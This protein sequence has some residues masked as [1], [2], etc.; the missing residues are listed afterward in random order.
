MRT[1]VATIT[2]VVLFSAATAHAVTLRQWIDKSLVEKQLKPGGEQAAALATYEVVEWLHAGNSSDR[3]GAEALAAA[4]ALD[5]RRIDASHVAIR[6]GPARAAHALPPAW[7]HTLAGSDWLAVAISPTASSP[8]DT[9]ALPSQGWSS[10]PRVIGDASKYVIDDSSALRITE[11]ALHRLQHDLHAYTATLR[12]NARVSFQNAQRNDRIATPRQVPLPSARNDVEAVSSK[13]PCIFNPDAVREAVDLSLDSGSPAAVL[14]PI[15]IYTDSPPN[16]AATMT[17]LLRRAGVDACLRRYGSV[18]FIE[19]RLSDQAAAQ[20]AAT[21]PLWVQT[22][23]GAKKV[24]VKWPAVFSSLSDDVTAILDKSAES[25][26]REAAGAAAVSCEDKST[27]LAHAEM[28]ETS[29]ESA[30]AAIERA[31]HALP[32][33]LAQ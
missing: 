1:A 8:I 19:V 33:A 4:T 14:V 11:Q 17:S 29:P 6:L 18:E 7:I 21:K 32:A 23:D 26:G 9:T 30:D 2:V 15:A 25:F 12:G 5:V 10:A 22:I 3:V 16:N 28:C 31:I 24:V 20:I 13:G 27:Q